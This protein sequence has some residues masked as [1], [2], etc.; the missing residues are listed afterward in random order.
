MRG[1]ECARIT[2]S[3][4][5]LTVILA[6]WG[7]MWIAGRS[8]CAGARRHPCPVPR[9]RSDCIERGALLTMAR[10]SRSTRRPTPTPSGSTKDEATAFNGGRMRDPV[11]G[12][13]Q[14]ADQCPCLRA[15]E[16]AGVRTHLVS[17]VGP[18][19]H[20]HA[21]RDHSGRGCPNVIG[22]AK[23]FGFD[24]GIGAR[25]MVE[26]FYKSRTNDPPMSDEHALI[27]GWAKEW[28]LAYLRMQDLGQRC[29]PG[30][31]G[32]DGRDPRGLPAGVRSGP[33]W[34]H[35][36][37]RR[38]QSGWVA[39]GGRDGARFDKDA[40]EVISAIWATRTGRSFAGVQPRST[41]GA[42]GPTP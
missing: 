9:P 5:E 2:T 39:S 8:P 6:A 12:R 32:R 11:T 31:L 36:V 14:C 27:F 25:P 3:V 17:V 26:W 18:A 22:L 28:E 21:G 40:S 16:S 34:S 7:P 13:S 42:G 30:I 10:P 41:T 24:E 23:R 38:G 37:G 19:P 15:V 1:A 33:G 29:P 4:A 35:P 20:L